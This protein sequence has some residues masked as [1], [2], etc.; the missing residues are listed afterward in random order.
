MGYPLVNVS[1]N[2]AFLPCPDVVHA[3]KLGGSVGGTVQSCTSNE[4]FG[5]ASRLFV[6][7]DD[8]LDV[9]TMTGFEEY[10]DDGM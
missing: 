9:M 8:G 5:L 2:S 6:F 3:T 1:N 7:L 4:T 10:W